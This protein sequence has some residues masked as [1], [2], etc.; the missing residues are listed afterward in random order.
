[1]KFTISIEGGPNDFNF[2]PELI[3]SDTWSKTNVEAGNYTICF[4]TESLPNFKQCFN[5]VITEPQDISVLS[6]I[7]ND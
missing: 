4:T 3:Q 1:M 2:T 7:A 5:V 6:A